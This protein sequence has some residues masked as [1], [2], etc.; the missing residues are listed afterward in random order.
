MKSELYRKK[1]DTRDELLINILDFI[2]HIK[3]HQAALSEQHA[4]SSHELQIPLMLT[5]EFS[6]IYYIPVPT[7]SLEQ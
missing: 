3:E 1:V 4:M 2:A 5:A 7:L 6:N